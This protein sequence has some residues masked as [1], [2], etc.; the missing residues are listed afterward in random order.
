MF[1]IFYFKKV[2]STMDV[3]KDYP[4]NT[5]IVA[6]KQTKGRG[7][8]VRNWVSE[9]SQNVYMSLKIDI[10]G[11]NYA[12]HVFR[13]GLVVLEAIERSLGKL[14]LELKWPNDILLNGKK[15]GGIL[16]EKDG[17]NLTIGLGLNINSSPTKTLFRASSLKDEGFILDKKV[18]LKNFLEEFGR[19]RMDSFETVRKKWL[20]RAYNLGKEITA[21]IGDEIFC[22]IFENLDDNGFLT[23]RRQNGEIMKIFSGDVF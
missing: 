8:Q 14:N 10:K 20:A 12:N 4:P 5:V 2:F 9:D 17:D 16:L 7:K 21:N 1:N 23:L 6:E 15:I 19:H 3:I 22:G 13:T 11:E 18:F